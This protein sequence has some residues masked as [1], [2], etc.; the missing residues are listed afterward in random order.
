MLFSLLP[1]RCF[2]RL[3]GEHPLRLITLKT[4]VLAQRRVG[5]IA[6]LCPIGRLLVVRFA[7]HRRPQIDHCGRVFVDQQEVLVR[8]RFLLAAVL[9]LL[10]CGVGGTLATAL[11]AVDDPIGRSLEREGAGGNPARVALRRHAESGEGPWQDGEQVMHPIVGLGLAQ[12]AWKPYMVCSG[13]VCWSTRMKSSLSSICGKRPL[14]PPPL[15]RWRTLPFQVLSGGESTAEAAAKA[16]S[17]R[18]HS[19][20]VSPVAARTSRGRS[21]KVE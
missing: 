20:F 7:D 10:L 3:L 18:S 14:A 11:G 9:C 2:F 16:G 4:C 8:M 19:S 1:A 12:S 15:W 5:G 13:L 17:T 6:Y 21:C